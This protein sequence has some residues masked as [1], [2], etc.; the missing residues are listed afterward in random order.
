MMKNKKIW[1]LGYVIGFMSLVALFILKDDE[2]LN[3]TLPFIFT[4]SVTISTVMLGHNK[5]MEKDSFYR[6]N[7]NDERNEKIRDKVNATVTPI[8]MLI[9]ALVAVICFSLDEYLPAIILAFGV[10]SFPVI[11]FFV[12]RYYEKRY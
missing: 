9:M 1:Y 5:R 12:S 11:S 3:R 10:F 2:T 8:Y 7:V 4:I 6:I